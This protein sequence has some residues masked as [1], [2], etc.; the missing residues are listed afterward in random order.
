MGRVGRGVWVGCTERG[1][2]SESLGGIGGGVERARKGFELLKAG[3]EGVEVCR[4]RAN[5]GKVTSF[6]PVGS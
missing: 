6:P 2:E 1:V 5:L 3:L 4:E